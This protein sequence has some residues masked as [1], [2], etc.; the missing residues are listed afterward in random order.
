MCKHTKI[1]EEI[2][3]KWLF[4]SHFRKDF[5]GSAA[6]HQ[7]PRESDPGLE[8]GEDQGAGAGSNSLPGT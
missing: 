6:P 7:L 8:R 4:S 5:V 2:L 3:S 1:Q